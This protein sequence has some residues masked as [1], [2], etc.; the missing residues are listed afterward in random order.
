MCI[1]DRVSTQ[2][3]G[4]AH[5]SDA[6]QGLRDPDRLMGCRPS[7]DRNESDGSEESTQRSPH[8]H[9][10]FGRSGSIP[11]ATDEDED[12]VITESWTIPGLRKVAALS[13]HVD[14]ITCIACA[15]DGSLL[16]TGSRDST[17]RVWRTDNWKQH[18]V[19]AVHEDAV[20]C[21]GFNPVDPRYLL[22]GSGDTT[23]RVHL[24]GENKT[25]MRLT[26][27]GHGQYS[28]VRCSLFSPQGDLICSCAELDVKLWKVVYTDGS[29]TGAKILHR[30][31]G[32]TECVTV[33]A[34][35][36]DGTQLASGSVDKTVRIWSIDPQDSSAQLLACL[37]V[38]GNNTS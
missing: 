29:L 25:T 17:V 21:V 34:F 3:T 15:A 28:E 36:P 1:R 37:E 20:H 32:H 31:Q 27:R 14:K 13:G 9:D 5:R 24:L 8:H 19:I 26:L 2:S 23:V 11:G 4:Y 30:L 38:L 35:N 22:T 18:S 6:G 7:H 33:A 10:R 12:A 16:A